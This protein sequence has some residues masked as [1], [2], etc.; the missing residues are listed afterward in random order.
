MSMFERRLQL[1]L[2]EDRYRRVSAR[3]RERG[4]SIARV[5]RDAIDLL[6]PSEAGKRSR[7]GE[8]ILRA[9]RMPVPDPDV[10]RVELD[11]LRGRRG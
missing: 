8:R 1:L 7:A 10:L 2:D 11:E 4:V 5:I 3:A 6:V 9:A